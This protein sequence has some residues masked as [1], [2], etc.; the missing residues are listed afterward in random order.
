MKKG[1]ALLLTLALVFSASVPAFAADAGGADTAG[2]GTGGVGTAADSFPDIK[3]HWAREALISAVDNGLLNGSGGS[4]HPDDP[5]TR[6]QLAAVVNRA[7]GAAAEAALPAG[8]DVKADAWYAAD[9]RKTVQMGTFTGDSGGKLRPEDPI[10]RQETF[11]VL[12]R[13]FKIASGTAGDLAVFSDAGQVSAWAAGSVAGLVKAGF[14]TGS[15][16]KLDLADN[17]TRAQFATMLSRMISQYITEAGTYEA[18]DVASGGSVLVR[19]P[20]VTLKGITVKGDLI[21]GDGVGDG[22]VTLDSVTVL[23][24]VVVRG[25]GENSIRITGS[26]SVGTVIVTRIDGKVRVVVSGGAEVE[27]VYIDDG[28][29]DVILEGQIGDVLVEASDIAV[30]TVN[31]TIDSLNVEGDN[32]ELTVGSG[33]SVDTLTVSAGTSGTEISNSGTVDTLEANGTVS[34]TGRGAIEEAVVALTGSGS[35]FETAPANT[36]VQAGASANIGGRIIDNSSGSRSLS[37][38]AEPPAGNTGG[39]GGGG[40]PGGDDND[41]NNGGTDTTVPTALSFSPADNNANAAIGSNLAVTFSENVSAVS[42]KHIYIK[43]SADNGVE[44]DIEATGARVTVNGAVATIDPIYDLAYDTAYYVQIEA[45][46]F[47]DGSNNS[48]AGINDTTTWNFTMAAGPAEDPEDIT[49]ATVAITAP[50]AGAAPQ[51]AAAVQAATN[52]ADFTVSA[53]SW[54]GDLTPGGKFKAATAYTVTVTLTSKNN[55]EFQAAAFTPTVAEAASVGQ[56]TMVGSGVSNTVQFTA[57]YNA[58]AALSITAIAVKAQ[59]TDLVYTEGESLSLAGLEVTFTYNDG[60]TEDMTLDGFPAKGITADPANGTALTVAD[61]NGQPV[62]LTCNGQTAATNNLSVAPVDPEDITG[63]TVAITAPVLGVT[64]ED[65]AAVEAAADNADYTVTAVAWNEELTAAGKFRAG[66]AYTATVTLT[67]KNGKEF[68]AAAFTPAVEGAA[69]VGATATAGAGV[70]NTVTFTVTYAS[71][72]ALALIGITVS[73]QPNRMNYNEMSE[74]SG[75]LEL[76]GMIVTATNNDGS[77]T[78]VSF[79]DGTAAGFTATPANGTQLTIAEHHGHPVTITHTATGLT[80]VTVNLRVETPIPLPTAQIFMVAPV[81]GGIPQTTAQIEASTMNSDITVHSVIWN[82]PLTAGGKFKADTVYT[83]TIVLKSKNGRQFQTGPFVPTVTMVLAEQADLLDTVGQTTTSGSGV[84][85]TVTFTV[86]FVETGDLVVTGIAVTNPPDKMNYTETIDGV[87]ALNGLVVTE[88]HND[89]S[90]TAVTFTDGTAA[91]YSTSPAN[92]T[93]LTAAHNGQ[94]VTI[95]HTASGQTANTVALTVADAPLSADA[96]LASVAGLFDATPGGEDGSDPAQAITWSISVANEKATLGRSDIIPA[97]EA[98][99]KLY[100]DAAFTLEITGINALALVEGGNTT[101]YIKVTAEDSTVK[102]YAVTIARAE[103]PFDP[104]DI[105]AA[106]VVITAPVLGITPKDAAAVETATSNADYTVTDVD[107]NEELTLAGKFKAGQTYTATVVL[108][109][110][111]NK[112]F[113]AAPFAP[114]VAGSESVSQTITTGTGVGNTV[115]F[116][117]TYASTGALAVTGITVTAQMTKY[118]YTAIPSQ[119]V[120]DLSGMVVTATNN[121]GSTTTVPFTDGTAPGYTATPANGTLLSVAEHDDHPVIITHTDSG[122]TAETRL[123]NVTAPVPLAAAGVSMNAPILGMVP[124]TTAQIEALNQRTDYTVD[125]VIWNESLTDGGKFKAASVYSA[126][127]VLKSKN[128]REFRID[129]FTPSVNSAEFVG[130]TTAS[131]PGVGN[132]VTFTV[133]FPATGALAVIGITVTTQPEKMNYTET[134]DGILALDGMVVTETHNDLSTTAV[135]FADGTADGYTTSPANGAALT[136][137]EHHGHSVT[138]THTASSRTGTTGLL[139]VAAAADVTAPEF[140]AGYPKAG[141]AQ[142]AGS[143]QVEILVQVNEAGTAYYVVVADG[144]A[145]PSAAQVMEGHDSTGGAALAS[146]NDAVTANTEKSFITAA[147]PADSA[148]YDV[149]VVAR[150]GAGNA[151]AATK[152]DVVTPAA[153][154]G[155]ITPPE[156]ESFLPAN[157]SPYIAVNANMIITFNENVIAVDGKNIY[158]KNRNDDSTITTI[159]ATDTTQVTVS[160]AQVTINPADDLVES[161]NYY[162]QIEAGA[163][164]DESNNNY[165]GIDDTSWHFTAIL[166]DVQLTSLEE[167]L[168]ANFPQAFTGGW[169]VY[170]L[171][172]TYVEDTVEITPTLEGATVTW[173]VSTDLEADP[174]AVT[175][176]EAAEIPLAVGLN[177]ITIHVEKA[178]TGSKEYTIFVTRAAPADP[179]V[180]L[181]GLTENLLANFVPDF[182]GGTYGYALEATYAESTVNITPTLE[183]ATITWNV[184]TDGQPSPTTVNSGEAAAIPLTAVG[185]NTITIHVEKEG[186][187]ARDYVITV[188]RSEDITPS[189]DAS[190]VSWGGEGAA[191]SKQATLNVL[192]RNSVGTGLA[193][194]AA[195]DFSVKVDG[196]A[197]GTFANAPFSNFIDAGNG[198]YSVIFTGT[199]DSKGYSLTDLTV[200]GVV[201]EAGP[202]MVFT[203]AAAPAANLTGLAENLEAGFVPGFSGTTYGYA[204]AAANEETSVILT[205]TLDGAAI[206]YSYT[207]AVSGPVTD[208]AVASGTGESINLAVGDNAVTIEVEKA[209][210]QTKT[211]TVT[212]TRAAPAVDTVI[213]LAAIQGVTVPVRGAVPSAE[214]A[215]T[216]QYTGTVIWAPNDDSFEAETV[217]TA[218]I[219]LTA[220]AGYTLSGVAENFFTVAGADSDTNAANSGV[221]TAVFPATEEEPDTVINIAAIG[222]TAPVRGAVPAA[223]IAETDQYTGTVTWSPIDNPFKAATIYTATI[224]LTPKEGYTLTGVAANFFTVA[225]ADSDTNAANSGMVTAIFPATEATPVNIAA[226]QGVT[227]PVIGAAPAAA[228]TQT[229][230]Y[231]GTVAWAP[232]HNPFGAETVYTATITLTPKAGYTF[233]GVAENFFTVAG[234]SPVTNTANTGVVTAV[235]PATE[236]ADVTAPVFADGYPKAGAAQAPASRQVEILVQANEAGTA[237]YA[238]VAD[239][240]TAPSA[241]Q[242]MAGDDST[243]A[244]ALAAASGFVTADTQK[245]FVINLPADNTAYD[246][247]VVV[248]DGSNNTTA[249]SKV[250]VTTPLFPIGLSTLTEDLAA[251]FNPAFASGIHTYT[252]DAAGSENTVNIKPTSDDSTTITWD[253]NTDEQ[254]NPTTIN[255]GATARIPLAVGVNVV[256]IHVERAGYAPS[257]YVITVTRAVPPPDVQLT[258]L[259]EDFGAADFSPAFAGDSYAYTLAAANEDENVGITPTLEGATITWDVDTD[260]NPA[261]AVNSG[262]TASIPLEEGSNVITIHVEKA[263]TTAKNYVIIVTRAYAVNVESLSPANGAGDVALNADFVI[264]FNKNV[265]AQPGKF[266]TVRLYSDESIVQAI[267]ATDLD[268]VTVNGAEVTIDAPLSLLTGTLYYINIDPGAFKDAEDHEFVGITGKTAWRFTAA[269]NDAWAPS[270]IAYS[271]ADGAVGA[272]PNTSLRLTFDENVTRAPG[273]NIKLF[274]TIPDAPDQLMQY[275]HTVQI[276]RNTVTIVFPNNNIINGKDYYILIEPGAFKDAGNNEYAGISDAVTWNFTTLADTDGPEYTALSPADDAVNVPVGA[277]LAMTF[278]EDVRGGSGDYYIYIKKSEDDS[279]AATIPAFGGGLTSWYENQVTIDPEAD[280]EPSTEYYVTVD[281]GAFEDMAGNVFA[282]IAGETAWNFTTYAGDVSPPQ[283]A[284]ATMAGAKKMIITFDE[285]IINN[286]GSAEALKAAI[287]VSSNAADYNGLA[288]ED[289]VTIEGSDLVI[290]FAVGLVS[291]HDR[292]A[293]IAASALKDAAGNVQNMEITTEDIDDLAYV[294]HNWSNGNRRMTITFTENIHNNMPDIPALKATVTYSANGTDYDPLAPWDTVSISGTDLIIDFAIPVTGTAN[295]IKLPDYALRDAA[296]NRIDSDI[297]TGDRTPPAYLCAALSDANHRVTLTFSDDIF[298]YLGDLEQLKEAKITFA[299]DGVDFANL[300]SADSVS[301]SGNRLIIDFD[302]ALSGDSGRIRLADRALADAN[303]VETPEITT[304]PIFT[305]G[306]A[307]APFLLGTEISDLNGKVALVFDEDIYNNTDGGAELK[308][309]V[310]FAANGTDFAPLAAGDA[311]NISGNR[312][313]VDFAAALGGNDNRIRVNAETLRDYSGNVLYNAVTTATVAAWPKGNET[314]AV[315]YPGTLRNMDLA[316]ITGTA[317]SDGDLIS[318]KVQLKRNADNKYLSA[319]NG[320]FISAGPVDLTVTGTRNWRVS[321]TGVVLEEGQYTIT[322]LANDGIDGT[323]V[324]NLVFTVDKTAPTFSHTP[325]GGVATVTNGTSFVLHFNE[326]VTGVYN[327]YFR[328]YKSDGTL[329]TSVHCHEGEGAGNSRIAGDGTDTITITP[330]FQ[331][332]PMAPLSNYYVLMDA[333]AFKDAAGNNSA[334]ITDPAAWN[335]TTPAASLSYSGDTFTESLTNLGAIDTQITVTLTGEAF[336][337]PMYDPKYTVTGLPTGLY[338]SITRNGATQL[339][340]GLTGNADVHGSAASTTFTLTFNNGAYIGGRADLVDNSSKVFSIVFSD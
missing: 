332:T 221:I 71:T 130:P 62:T 157:S 291:D 251:S 57:T 21:V 110:K 258:S 325:E 316:L 80:A 295:R 311:V 308:A 87:L 288:A 85:N 28:S 15:D 8:T 27:V 78:D 150:D 214:I 93:A 274:E 310:T 282:G 270:A 138:V 84:G 168:A 175:S 69:S 24:R 134:T 253:V 122:C 262:D 144:A 305:T 297:T 145:A 247:Y 128:G 11:A 37:V 153:P 158:I 185:E 193:G 101:A 280:L 264:N 17:I 340:L 96:G 317:S 266:I 155:D 259:A 302:A 189:G 336:T 40:N 216:A 169:Y 244:D 187:S 75:R 327:K 326:A 265:I 23:G 263:G 105:A 48:F 44:E 202:Y 335:F 337:S 174:T 213:N 204:L 52:H 123:L 162:V 6:A 319:N 328:I 237:Y 260:E 147:L 142:A 131:G 201:I 277:N 129:P 222:V 180:Q 3:T 299:A 233:N 1:L 99:F 178:G 190:G 223:V 166:P 250:D 315:T 224:I 54:N 156:V 113:R 70:G 275:P 59:P 293:K 286:T 329:L 218:T 73:T 36:T 205:A 321:L 195:D 212:I 79:T 137:A 290:N 314:V 196:G 50:A 163:F 152:V 67:S 186:T 12:A 287:Q 239:G 111:N 225:G 161:T 243:D 269:P 41:G 42:G 252:L 209:G 318:V 115:T 51:D 31:A 97:A 83:A 26:S 276:D 103:P 232:A 64:P 100:S 102:Y 210:H 18:G 322:A 194:Y 9:M 82:E 86:T 60:T 173:D 19:A 136:V 197:A 283:Y 261:A 118:S 271:P 74:L 53:V 121:D 254:L 132:T 91:G 34:V 172:A 279:I 199:Q 238:V 206:K 106:E 272:A 125:S 255:Y 76:N 171:A 39:G 77:T 303:N 58:T 117:V 119:G 179:A 65:A 294:T 331:Y 333:G 151:T 92:G 45:G 120:L 323:T 141:A 230:Q 165:A 227:V 16:G 72:G 159:E 109:S 208:K 2:A 248:K 182:A 108:T 160:G 5:L 43:K 167:N 14:L 338:F 289:I 33:S 7:F 203:P 226:I 66:Q 207:D 98:G 127:I 20:G 324:A 281:A 133:T 234:A 184:N 30:T 146:A 4:M 330:T 61:H 181:T 55:K 47:K 188:N 191:G 306:D 240:A 312:L 140:A 95:T 29:D 13:A 38:P 63:A 236:A 68:Q 267:P 149:Y 296:G 124:Q 219:T 284:S 231:T 198:N 285:N 228:I 139:T 183:G 211:Y 32:I 300:V 176:G 257:D 143:R 242:V 46:A 309:A 245:S 170:T 313:I 94:P 104:E 88:A 107:W 49:A 256:T 278:N 229:N 154:G 126:T 22:D 164:K 220:K 112:E 292:R 249:V 90:T 307:G 334:A 81:L 268:R 114:T 177:I 89:G 339:T 273:D 217:Y 235:F 301:I 35:Q 246:V 116:T 10:T 320:T 215:E 200:D 25:G 304:E 298:V 148:A 192:V 56:T 135:T 241:A